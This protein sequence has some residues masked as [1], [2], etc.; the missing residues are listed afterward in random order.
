MAVD[1]L[2]RHD[3]FVVVWA[4]P[5]DCCGVRKLIIGNVLACAANVLY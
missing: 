2:G 3:R 5:V 1:L 4:I